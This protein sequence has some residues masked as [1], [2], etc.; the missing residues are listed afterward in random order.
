ML[1]VLRPEVFIIGPLKMCFASYT[2]QLMG[3]FVYVCYDFRSELR[4]TGQGWQKKTHKTHVFWAAD[5][6][7]GKDFW[8]D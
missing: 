8:T 6:R 7:T 1:S 5:I 4:V 3:F 2:D